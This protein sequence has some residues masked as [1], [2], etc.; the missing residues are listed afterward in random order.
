MQHQDTQGRQGI[1]GLFASTPVSRTQNLVMVDRQARHLKKQEVGGRPT[2]WVS[3]YISGNYGLYFQF[4]APQ[5]ILPQVLT[6]YPSRLP[7]KP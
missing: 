1:A 4:C 5:A 2:P 3:F 7:A 6:V